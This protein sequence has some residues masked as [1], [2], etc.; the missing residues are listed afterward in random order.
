MLRARVKA[1]HIKSVVIHKEEDDVRVDM[2]TGDV[3]LYKNGERRI[4][5]S[6]Q[7]NIIKPTF[8][9]ADFCQCGK[10]KSSGDSVTL[11]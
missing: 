4:L 11:V 5:M 3:V 1:P 2:R 6:L 10:F 7:V 8:V 9:K